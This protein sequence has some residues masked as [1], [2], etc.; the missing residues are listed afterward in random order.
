M[1]ESGNV[2]G[3]IGLDKSVYVRMRPMRRAL[4]ILPVLLAVL[5]ILSGCGKNSQDAVAVGG[6]KYPDGARSIVSL[7]PGCTEVLLSEGASNQLVGRTASCNYPEIVRKFPVVASIKPDWEK[8]AGA[9]RGHIPDLIVYDPDLYK[10]DDVAMM[11][12]Y[13][14]LEPFPLGGNSIDEFIANLRKLAPLYGGETT[15]STYIDQIMNARAGAQADPIQPTPTVA[16]IMPGEGSEHM[17]AGIDS[18]YADEIKAGSAK[19]V[20]PSGTNFVTLNAESLLQMNPDVIITA[21]D[22]ESFTNDKRFQSLA[23]IKNKRILAISQDAMLRRGCR[24]DKV[25][26]HI[27]DSVSNV[28]QIP[29][30]TG[31]ATQ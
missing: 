25:I 10:P 26:Q 16:L 31:G 7:A 8:I 6:V 21:G 13:S 9:A 20:G 24:V 15:M 14:R 19:P 29:A 1:T 4:R 18:F 28:M 22:S 23:A 11:K 5:V 27:H 2:L 12:K 3:P 30:T 17:I